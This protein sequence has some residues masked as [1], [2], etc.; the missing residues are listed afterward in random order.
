MEPGAHIQPHV[1]D[2]ASDAPH[3]SHSYVRAARLLL[4]IALL[5]GV[6]LVYSALPESD[7]E[8][9]AQ[10]GKQSTLLRIVRRVPDGAGIDEEPATIESAANDNTVD[11]N[12]ELYSIDTVAAERDY[13]AEQRARVSFRE[14]IRERSG[15]RPPISARFDASNAAALRIAPGRWWIHARYTTDTLEWTWRVPVNVRGREQTIELTSDNVYTR[16]Q[17]Y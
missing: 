6:W 16:S 12:V 7:H 9:E 2:D 11:A 13:R 14:F 10:A 4:V 5:S 8:R 15:R 17:S 3:A 1:N